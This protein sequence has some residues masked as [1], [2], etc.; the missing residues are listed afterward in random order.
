VI[1]KKNEPDVK[2]FS[3]EASISFQAEDFPILRSPDP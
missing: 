1:I 2:S 3:T